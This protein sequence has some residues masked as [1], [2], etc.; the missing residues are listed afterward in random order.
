MLGFGSKPN[1]QAAKTG[2]EATFMTDVLEASRERPV[3][4]YF[5]APWC[6]PC[7]T[8]GPELERAVADSAGK[9]ELVKFDVEECPQLAA[10]LRIQSIPAV[11]AFAGT[12]LAD[13]FAGAKAGAELREFIS[14]LARMASNGDVEEL[15]KQAEA[16]LEQGAAVEA[17]QCYS[18]VLSEDR[19]NASGYEGLAR[20]YL[21]LGEV[22]KAEGIL[23][24]VPNP[25]A[26]HAKVE[27]ARAAVELAKQAARVGSASTLKQR[28]NSN[29][30]DHQARMDLA[31]A[32]MAEGNVEGAVE[33][34][35]ELFRLDREWQDGA[36][37]QQLIKIFDSLK[38]NDPVALRGRRRLSS[39]IFS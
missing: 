3:I 17:A 13:H 18:A 25:I 37:R 30:G 4:A 27:G 22:N 36:A 33:E 29:P 31:M 19:G 26:S 10:Q 28:V 14:K 7:R 39:M 6:G 1:S 8:F 34:L 15:L 32:W 12:K 2:S 16:L 11:F 24:S 21:A 23:N 35:L 5:S 9:V 20:A 38:P